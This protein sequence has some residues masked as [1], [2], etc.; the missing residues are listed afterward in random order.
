MNRILPLLLI[1]STLCNW[2]QADE[3]DKY[4][5]ADSVIGVGVAD[6]SADAQLRASVANLP[7]TSVDLDDL[8]IDDEDWSWA[9]EWRWRFAPKWMLVGLAYRFSQEGNRSVE[10]DFNFDGVEFTAGAK[11]DTELSVDTYILD[12]MYQV[13]RSERG[14]ILL[15]GGIHA[16]DLDASIK[17]LAFVGNQEREVS[18][19]NSELL[20][21]LPNLRAQAFYS[22]GNGWGAGVAMGWLSANVDDYDGSF[23][24]LHPRLGYAFSERWGVT[25]GYQFV[26][27]DLTYEKSSRRETEFEVEFTGPTLFLNYRF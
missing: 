7:E 27:L 8:G 21:P 4:F 12:L 20:A 2:A 18:A 5:F 23:V 13:Y 26:D 19:A 15:G 22:F 17:A 9:L 6:Q 11:A 10:R 25:L 3:G 14:E 1:F 16:I 24:Y